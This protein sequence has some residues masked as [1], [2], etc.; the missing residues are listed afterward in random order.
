MKRVYI[1]GHDASV[2]SVFEEFGW[3]TVSG[4]LPNSPFDLAVFTGGSDIDPKYY[5]EKNTDSHISDYSRRRDAFEFDVYRRLTEIGVPK[6]GICRGGQLFNIANGGRLVQHIGGHGGCTH[7]VF[8]YDTKGSLGKINSCH[9]QMMVPTEEAE[10]IAFSLYSGGECPE[11]IFYPES[12]DLCF[13][14]HP[15]WGHVNTTDLFF[16]NLSYCLDL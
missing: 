14:A 13:Q 5:G 7:E 11:I 6:V 3:E 16:A 2:S 12:K 10:L 15:E 1:V 8:H 9:H 4:N